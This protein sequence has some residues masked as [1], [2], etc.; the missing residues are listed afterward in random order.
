M[1]NTINDNGSVVMPNTVASTP[2]VAKPFVPSILISIG[3]P[4]GYDDLALEIKKMVA[5]K[6]ANL[7]N[8]VIRVTIN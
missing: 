4:S 2:V 3:L 5:S 8:K 7:E 6:T 1:P